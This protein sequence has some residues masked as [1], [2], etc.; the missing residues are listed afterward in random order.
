MCVAS[1]L[2]GALEDELAKCAPKLFNVTEEHVVILPMA[3]RQPYG[4][5]CE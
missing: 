1:D 2:A 3:W 5:T 4:T